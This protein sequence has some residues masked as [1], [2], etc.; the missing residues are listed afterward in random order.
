MTPDIEAVQ[1]MLKDHRIWDATGLDAGD[2]A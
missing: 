1:D 2:F